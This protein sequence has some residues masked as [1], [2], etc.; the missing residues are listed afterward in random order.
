M[1]LYR[2]G[3]SVDSA[4]VEAKDDESSDRY[5]NIT[6]G[7]PPRGAQSTGQVTDRD[8]SRGSESNAPT[9]LS[10]SIR[11]DLRVA[12]KQLSSAAQAMEYAH[13]G[14][15]VDVIELSIA[16][17]DYRKT[18]GTLWRYREFGMQS[19]QTVIVFAQQALCEHSKDEELTLQQCNGLKRLVS[20]LSNRMLSKDDLSEAMLLLQEAGFDTFLFF[21]PAK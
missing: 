18:L 5:A 19:W 6:V 14:E 3:Q 8:V 11:R 9:P 2:T 20:Y 17:D 16:V 12:E 13:C 10:P 4:Q 15:G 7:G 1:S 21:S